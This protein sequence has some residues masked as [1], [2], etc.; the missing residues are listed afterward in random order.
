[1]DIMKQKIINTKEMKKRVV[2]KIYRE[3]SN[4]SDEY[5]KNLLPDFPKKEKDTF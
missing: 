2:L 3:R 4:I 5:L 1:M